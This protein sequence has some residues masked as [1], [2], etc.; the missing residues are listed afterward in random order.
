MATPFRSQVLKKKKLP[1]EEET[2]RIFIFGTFNLLCRVSSVSSGVKWTFRDKTFF[3]L[4][5]WAVVVG[6]E[7]IREGKFCAKWA[8]EFSRRVFAWG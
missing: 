3:V 4:H 7:G 2:P 5:R 6:E 8:S 1:D